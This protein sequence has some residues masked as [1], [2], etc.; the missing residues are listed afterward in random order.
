M[1]ILKIQELTDKQD[2]SLIIFLFF[3]KVD[4]LKRGPSSF[5]FCNSWMLNKECNK[6]IESARKNSHSVGWASFFFSVKL[7]KVKAAVKEWFPVF[8]ENQKRKENDLIG[9]EKILYISSSCVRT[10]YN[11]GRSCFLSLTYLGCLVLTFKE[12]SRNF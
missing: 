1:R 3:L 10:Q 5:I 7:R 4:L 11:V 12:I 2:C 9:M 6:V 8:Q